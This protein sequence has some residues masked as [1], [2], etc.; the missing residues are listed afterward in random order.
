M[1]PGKLYTFM[2][3]SMNSCYNHR[4][5]R[6]ADFPPKNQTTLLSVVMWCL[7]QTGRDG[8][9]KTQQHFCVYLSGDRQHSNNFLQEMLDNLVAY[10]KEIIG[11]AA[12]GVQECIL[13]R[14][15]VWNDGCRDSLRTYGR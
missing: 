10:F 13:Q 1:V 2:G 9:L 3:F 6:Q 5:E 11:K 7:A 4:E 14:L 8:N 15:C 12:A